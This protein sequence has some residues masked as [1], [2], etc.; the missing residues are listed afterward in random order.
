MIAKRLKLSAVV[1]NKF[2]RHCRLPYKLISNYTDI[3][4]RDQIHKQDS[5]ITIIEN[6]TNNYRY[7]EPNT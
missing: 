3:P 6:N 2:T 7:K 1:V 4:D 5:R